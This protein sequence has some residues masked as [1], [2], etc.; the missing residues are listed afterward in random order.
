M[1]EVVDP[2]HTALVV[3][4]MQ[5]DFCSTDGLFA[6]SGKDV[7]MLEE[8]MPRLS[9]FVK[10]ARRA[11]VMVL[12]T[13]NTTLPNGR[14]D[15]PAWVRTKAMA[16]HDPEYTLEGSWGQAFC[17]GMEPR[18]GEPVIKKHRSSGF[19]EANMD[20]VLRSS[21]IQSLIVTGCLSDGCV[22]ATALQARFLNYYVVVPGDCI[23]ST[24]RE[25][26]EAAVKL[27]G[28]VGSEEILKGWPSSS[29]SGEAA[30]TRSSRAVHGPTA[31]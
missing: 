24:N 3:I 18:K 17:S 15:S 8:L 12:H 29:S 13:Q 6:K 11:G 19:V 22:L 9:A 7:S 14:S 23:G 25:R 16:C 21:G 26:H 2:K 5:N 10:V 1:D 20:M 27:L 31:S 4:D 30:F 28:P